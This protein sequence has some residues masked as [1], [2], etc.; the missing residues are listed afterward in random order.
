MKKVLFGIAL[1][2]FAMLLHMTQIWLPF[3]GDLMGR[4]DFAVLIAAVGLVIAGIG[5]FTKDK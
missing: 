4:G 1:I 5:A 3:V 2:L